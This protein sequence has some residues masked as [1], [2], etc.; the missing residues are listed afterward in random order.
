MGKLEANVR[1][2]RPFQERWEREGA[3]DMERKRD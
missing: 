3:R 2:E 1:Y